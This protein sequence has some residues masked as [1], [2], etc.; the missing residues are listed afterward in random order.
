LCTPT[1]VEGVA[2]FSEEPSGKI[3]SSIAL[4]G[5]A[6]SLHYMTQVN[7]NGSFTFP[8]VQNGEYVLHTVDGGN[9]YVSSV[10][11]GGKE[12]AS[13]YISIPSDTSTV[14]LQAELSAKAA[15]V[16]GYVSQT[17]AAD[18]KAFVVIQSLESGQIWVTKADSDTQFFATGLPPGAYR[19]YAWHD[20][21]EVE[22][23][24][25]LFLKRFT[26]Q[27]T[28]VSLDETTHATQVEVRMIG[29]SDYE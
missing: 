20:V 29:N 25:P 19:L 10:S 1:K 23:N 12:Q 3:P 17:D 26:D 6:N 8:F 21:D 13:P 4:D 28:I 5:R 11:I 9:V 18:G 2:S 27:S 16:A 15:A 14:S 24:N 7:K 22:Y